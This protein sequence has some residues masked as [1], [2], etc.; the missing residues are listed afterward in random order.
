MREIEALK[1]RGL[2]FLFNALFM[3]VLLWRFFQLFAKKP[4]KK[5]FLEFYFQEPFQS[6]LPPQSML[7]YRIRTFLQI[8]SSGNGGYLYYTI[9]LHH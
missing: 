4:F 2:K 5:S 8:Y 1:E 7:S 9:V 3:E 6:L